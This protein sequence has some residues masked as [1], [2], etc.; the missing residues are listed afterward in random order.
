MVWHNNNCR[1]VALRKF[2]L[3]TTGLSTKNFPESYSSTANKIITMWAFE[4]KI[5]RKNCENV[6]HMRS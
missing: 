2:F 6:I 1:T 5:L 4:G 3:L